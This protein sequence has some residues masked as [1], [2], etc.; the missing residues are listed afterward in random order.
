VDENVEPTRV[1]TDLKDISAETSQRENRF[2]EPV[3]PREQRFQVRMFSE[4]K[5]MSPFF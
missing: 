1:E 5:E 3:T 4:Q 2:D